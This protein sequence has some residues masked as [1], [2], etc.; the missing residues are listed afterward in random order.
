MPDVDTLR[1]ITAVSQS[2][3]GILA[4]YKAQ[5]RNLTLQGKT[6]RLGLYNTVDAITV[7]PSMCW[8]NEGYHGGQGRKRI[9]YDEL[10][11]P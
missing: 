5:A 1:C 11:L 7:E 4:N 6:D 8:P 2:V 10:S 9:M 3:M